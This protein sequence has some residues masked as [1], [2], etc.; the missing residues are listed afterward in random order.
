MPSVLLISDQE[1]VLVILPAILAAEG[2]QVTRAS[3]VLTGLRQLTETS[4]NIVIVDIRMPGLSA[5]ELI[6]RGR[7][8]APGTRFLAIIDASQAPD[9]TAA[10]AA[11][12]LWADGVLKLP[13]RQA[14]LLAVVGEL[15]VESR[16][17]G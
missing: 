11:G 2:Y 17:F 9:A 15:L 1:A 7:V 5:A 6:S 8:R 3:E 4:F 10:P 16:A 14:D 12:K 13:F